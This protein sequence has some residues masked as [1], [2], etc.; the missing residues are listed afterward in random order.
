MKYNLFWTAPQ[1]A[2][3]TCTAN[4][5]VLNYLKTP[6]SCISGRFL[7]VIRTAFERQ[8]VIFTA[9][10]AVRHLDLRHLAIKI[11]FANFREKKDEAGLKKPIT[12][13]GSLWTIFGQKM[14]M[15][16]FSNLCHN[17]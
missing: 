16:D 11:V 8:T 14:R 13:I 1:E 9:N 5:F 3:N 2:G 6:H 7:T 10:K 12:F 15:G 4:I 17:F